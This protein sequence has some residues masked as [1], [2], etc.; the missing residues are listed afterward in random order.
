MI[1]ETT[2]EV[3]LKAFWNGAEDGLRPATYSREAVALPGELLPLM[4][5]KVTAKMKLV[6]VVNIMPLNIKVYYMLWKN[7]TS[8]LVTDITRRDR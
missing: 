5:F 2:T 4:S 3:F 6:I 1:L 7:R 8:A